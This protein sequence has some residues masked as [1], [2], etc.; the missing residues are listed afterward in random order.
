MKK[1]TKH[2]E[3]LRNNA[4]PYKPKLEIS[5]N[6]R[7]VRFFTKN[8]GAVD[9]VQHTFVW[10]AVASWTHPKASGCFGSLTTAIIDYFYTWD[11]FGLASAK[12]FRTA[13]QLEKLSKLENEIN[14]SLFEQ[15]LTKLCS[16]GG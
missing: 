9:P 2:S 3:Q 5:F 7:G 4:V 15:G 6:F 16:Q 14:K 8:L 11:E 1:I 12:K 10:F 13:E